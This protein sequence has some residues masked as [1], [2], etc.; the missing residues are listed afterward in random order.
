M[1]EKKLTISKSIILT[2]SLFTVYNSN[3]KLN[4]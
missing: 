1:I 3:N 4:N 2:T